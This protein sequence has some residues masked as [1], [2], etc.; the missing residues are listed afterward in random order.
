MSSFRSKSE[1]IVSRTVGCKTK[2]VLADV[3]TCIDGKLMTGI[4]KLKDDLIKINVTKGNVVSNALL[5]DGCGALHSLLKDQLD[6]NFNKFNAYAVR[7]IFTISEVSN[8]TSSSNKEL[9]EKKYLEIAALRQRYN[10]SVVRHGTISNEN[11]QMEVVLSDMRN[12]LFQLRVG[13]QVLDEYNVQPLVDT[14]A[15]IQSQRQI[16]IELC[17]RSIEL[18]SEMSLSSIA[19]V[20]DDHASKDPLNGLEG[21]DFIEAPAG[22]II[23]VT[24]SIH[25]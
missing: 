20:P 24:K 19:D 13:A 6:A 12:A 15:H 10:D 4:K 14:M 17:Q 7:N 5:D 1:D 11:K 2:E 16:L 25:K 3:S 18:A 23:R 8:T 21:V 22:G 9:L